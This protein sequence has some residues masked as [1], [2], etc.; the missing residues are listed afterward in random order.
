MRDA[1]SNYPI[2]TA[3]IKAKPLNLLPWV[4]DRKPAP[5]AKDGKKG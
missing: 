2:I 3:E 4:D 1:L 5:W